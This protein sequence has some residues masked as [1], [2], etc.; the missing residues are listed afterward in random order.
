MKPEKAGEKW[1]VED[2]NFLFQN[3]NKKSIVK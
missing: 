3:W 2:S 1:T